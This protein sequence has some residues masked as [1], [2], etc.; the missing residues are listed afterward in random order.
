[1]DDIVLYTPELRG[2]VSDRFPGNAEIVVLREDHAGT[3]LLARLP[4]GGKIGQHR[5]FGSVQH[6]VLNGQYESEGKVFKAG[7]YRAFPKEAH[8]AP[9]TSD[10][11]AVILIVYDPL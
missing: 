2:E 8:V 9:I 11:R 5:H 1:M 6:F 3:T 7:T 10:A 4:A